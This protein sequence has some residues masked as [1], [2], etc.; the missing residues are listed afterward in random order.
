MTDH[1]SDDRKLEIV[2]EYWRVRM[3][4]GAV[5]AIEK[6]CVDYSLSEADIDNL[7]AQ[8]PDEAPDEH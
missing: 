7:V 1:I 6:V 8:F 4:H 5:A 3:T 2:R